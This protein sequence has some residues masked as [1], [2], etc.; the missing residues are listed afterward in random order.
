MMEVMTTNRIWLFVILPLFLI[1]GGVWYAVFSAPS[2]IYSATQTPASVL[3]KQ[4]PDYAMAEKLRKEGKH[5]LALASYQEALDAAD[6]D[7][8]RAQIALDIARATEQLG[9]YE[10]AVTR[11]K[12][13]TAD[14]SNYAITR[15]TALT[16]VGLMYYTYSGAPLQA[17]V[18]ETFKDSPYSS[19]RNDG[20]SLSMAYIKLFEHAASIYPLAL[21]EALIAHGYSNELL[22]MPNATSTPQGREYIAQVVRGLAAAAA[23]SARMRSAVEERPLIPEALVRAGSAVDNLATL[24]VISG[25]EQAESYFRDGVQYAAI[26]GDKPGNSYALRYA[27]FLAKRYGDA[28]AGDIRS[29]LASFRSGN[30]RDMY[31]TTADYLRSVRAE[32]AS[33]ARVESLIALGKIDSGFKGYLISLGW[34]ASDF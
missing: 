26:L 14:A 32:G 11:F 6:D 34:R 9:R 23:D 10:E 22:R 30:E 3:M 25:P 7:F 21:G 31:A 1:A 19:F 16:S 20:T 33:S 4:N 29:L 2:E 17:I 8:Q 5:D 24:G 12:A 13:I 15:A 28:R 18:T 27:S